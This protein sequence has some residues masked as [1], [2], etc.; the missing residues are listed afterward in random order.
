MVKESRRELFSLQKRYRR[1]A[2]NPSPDD[3]VVMANIQNQIREMLLQKALA[4]T[5]G[6]HEKNVKDLSLIAKT[7]MASTK[8]SQTRIPFLLHPTKGKVESTDEILTVATDFYT[9]LYS[10][11]P[12]DCKV[13][14]G[15]LAG[16]PTLN[17]QNI[18][19]LE[20]E[21]TVVECYNALKETQ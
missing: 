12:V 15:F 19:K 20:R 9:D 17:P 18:D 2:I 13:W 6:K 8:A 16:L 10:E 3:F 21:I 11:K 5:P 14:D 1:L 4:K 7:T